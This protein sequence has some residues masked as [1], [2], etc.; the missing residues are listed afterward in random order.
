MTAPTVRCPR[1]RVVQRF[2]GVPVPAYLNRERESML[3]KGL[4]SRPTRKH[5]GAGSKFDRLR[6]PNRRRL[7]QCVM[8]EIG[9]IGCGIM[10]QAAG[11]CVCE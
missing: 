9:K 8:L 3:R 1:T 2:D 11:T 6:S 10:M 5:A 7:M 4:A